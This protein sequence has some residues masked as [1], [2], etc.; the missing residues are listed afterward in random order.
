MCGVRSNIVTSVEVSGWSANDTPYFKPLVETAAAHFQIAEVSADKAYLSRRNFDT[1]KAVGGTAYIPFKTNTV[2]P[3]TD[4]E[5]ARLYHLFMLNRDTFLTHY[6]KRSNVETVFS[7]IK[8]KFGDAVRSKGDTAM[9]NEVLCKVLCHNI[10][11]VI[12]TME[13]LGVQPTFC[14]DSAVAQKVPV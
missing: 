8:A 11:V 6:H 14:A 2:E 1:V 4:D 10:C 5:W 13:E 7:M 9:I 3:T 12:Q